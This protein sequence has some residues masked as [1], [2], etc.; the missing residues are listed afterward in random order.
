MCSSDPISFFCA[1]M[2]V[3]DAI[4]VP[5][6]HMNILEAWLCACVHGARA[7]SSSLM[8]RPQSLTAGAMGP[9]QPL[10]QP[11]QEG[12]RAKAKAHPRRAPHPSTNAPDACS[13]PRAPRRVG[14]CQRCASGGGAPVCGV[15]VSNLGARLAPTLDFTPLAPLYCNRFSFT[16]YGSP[17]TRLCIGS[18]SRPRR[19]RCACGGGRLEGSTD[20]H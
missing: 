20:F 2:C 9:P 11:F 8:A 15:E 14:T 12:E 7:S 19:H 5:I 4:P 16:S 3:Y 17:L 1:A 18:S 6:G 10:S 13:C